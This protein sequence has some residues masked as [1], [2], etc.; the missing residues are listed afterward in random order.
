MELAQDH[1]PGRFGGGLLINVADMRQMMA[2][3][4]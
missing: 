2:F 4:Q 3:L 1:V